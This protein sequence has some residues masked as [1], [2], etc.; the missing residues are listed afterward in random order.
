MQQAFSIWIKFLSIHF[1]DVLSQQFKRWELAKSIRGQLEGTP[2]KSETKQCYKIHYNIIN[3]VAEIYSEDKTKVKP[4]E[5]LGA[6]FIGLPQ[7]RRRKKE[8]I[9]TREENS[10]EVVGSLLFK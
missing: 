9:E 6:I 3:I 5:D 4:R 1:I 7:A 2:Y 8:N 10:K